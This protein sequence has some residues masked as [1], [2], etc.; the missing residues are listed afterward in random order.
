LKFVDLTVCFLLLGGNPNKNHYWRLWCAHLQ[1][2]A[3][4]TQKNQ[5]F[6]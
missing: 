2:L 5:L 3:I 4:Y 6:S 1:D